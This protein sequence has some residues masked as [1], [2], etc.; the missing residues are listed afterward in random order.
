MFFV[1]SAL[2][3]FFVLSTLFVFFVLLVSSFFFEGPLTSFVGVKGVEF[4][5]S[6]SI[7]GGVETS[8]IETDPR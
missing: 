4:T 6:F 5:G 2:L 1:L 7:G 8:Y 3:V